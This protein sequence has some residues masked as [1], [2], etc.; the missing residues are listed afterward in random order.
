MTRDFLAWSVFVSV[1]CP[2]ILR[3]PSD[4]VLVTVLQ[5]ILCFGMVAVADHFE[6]S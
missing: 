4:L 2:M 5:I 3:N 1:L 6:R